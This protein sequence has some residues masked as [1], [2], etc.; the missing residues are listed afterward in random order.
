MENNIQQQIVNYFNN[1]YCL[2]HHNPRSIIF[3]VPNG[4]SRSIQ[5]AMMLKATGLFAGVSDLILIHNGKVIFI[6]VKQPT[7]K[8]QPI[9]LEFEQRVK[10]QGFEYFVVYSLEDFKAILIFN[11]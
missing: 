3:S 4:S 8:Q 1:T 9:Q 6:E 2:K 5:E 7:K 10:A 11:N